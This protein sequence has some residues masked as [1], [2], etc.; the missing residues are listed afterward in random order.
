L[1]KASSPRAGARG[2]GVFDR[3]ESLHPRYKALVLAAVL[4]AALCLLLPDIVFQGKLFLVPDA[5]AP[6]NFSVV[7]EKELAGGS[8]PL[9]NPYLFCG[10]PS[11]ASLAFTPYVYPPSFV[12]Y[13]LQRFLRFPEM[14]WLLVHY[15]LAGAGMYLLARALGCRASVSI[16]A[17]LVFMIL[18]NYV[19]MGANGH[20]SQAASIAYM[21]LALLLSWRVVA[22]PRRLAPAGLLAIVLGFQMLRGH[23]QIA[24]YTYLFVG[25]LFFF[26]AWALVKAR[27]R[28]GLAKGAVFLAAAFAAAVGIAAVLILPVREYAAHSIRGGGAGGGLDY[29]YATGWSLHPKEMLTFFFP[30]AYG[31]G[32]A[33]YWGAMPF[34]D[35]PNYLGVA[36][37]ILAAL[38]VALAKGRWKWFLLAAA[39][40][41]TVVS[42]GKFFPVLYG[43][44]FRYLP[45][46][47]KFRVPVMVL[48]VQQLAVVL[49][50][51]AGLEAFLSR[52]R[53]GT[54][55]PS[56]S[57]KRIKWALAAAAIALL[58]A[59]VGNG[60]LRA[61]IAGSAAVRAKVSGEWIAAAASAYAADLAKT[62][63]VLAAALL[64]LYLAAGKRVG[65]GAAAAALALVAAIDL[66][67]VNRS[68][69]HP[70]R[71]WNGAQPIVMGKDIRERYLRPDDAMRFFRSDT[72][73]FRVFPVPQAQ[74][75][76]WSHNAYPFS[77]NRFMSHGVFSLGGYH[78]AKLKRYQDVMDAM[79]ASFNEGRY[80]SAIVD[81][82]NAKYFY[83]AYPL[84]REGEG[85]PLVMSG[86]NLY[87]YENPRALPRIFFVDSVRVLPPAE[88][89]RALAA[90]AI[91]PAR[92]AILET[93]PPVRP[94]SAEGAHAR[95]TS[96]RANEIRVRARVERPCV[97]LLREI[98]YP[99]W[100]AEVNGAEAPVIAADYYLRA[101]ALEA[102]DH[103]IRVHLGSRP[104]R[105]SLV[106]SIVCF[107]A[108]VAAPVLSRA[109]AGRKR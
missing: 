27:D 81:M 90:N 61:G 83:S 89:L 6:L 79:F 8:Y 70:E 16:A 93:E 91:D 80:P 5:L 18:P 100:K 38:G 51:A 10:M 57:A 88:A 107:V 58:L 3:L 72:S 67:L 101:I 50:M 52:A 9:W 59:L 12:T 87:V 95:I 84:F 43:P 39:L 85:F 73:H 7:G 78:A 92:E 64:V 106:V 44:M 102:G 14:T 99:D 33:T 20:G 1:N 23:V 45:Y 2:T 96:Y 47:S 28:A 35:Y 24:Y 54:L 68:V 82:L 26:E 86:D 11:Y 109:T 25:L 53:A 62:L 40:A 15:L 60:G 42:F 98:W 94:E 46:F 104:L 71:T 76:Q 32:K 74:I 97:M 4:V 21:P 31:F 55:P 37:A 48:I 75:G 77:E 30:W 19:A 108:A 65:A 36:T 49:L 22:G 17:G 69:L 63:A 29:G 103:D 13:A 34:T 66:G 56:L 41:S 105:A